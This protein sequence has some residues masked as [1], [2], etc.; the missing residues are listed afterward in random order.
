MSVTPLKFRKEEDFKFFLIL[1]IEAQH[2]PKDPCETFLDL[3]VDRTILQKG[4]KNT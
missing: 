2:C 1:Y 3:K 4:L